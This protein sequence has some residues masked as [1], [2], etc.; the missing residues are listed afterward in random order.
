MGLKFFESLPKLM[1]VQPHS[2]A[3][4][5]ARV[6]S[7]EVLQLANEVLRAVDFISQGRWH[8]EPPFF[9]RTAATASRMFSSVRLTILSTP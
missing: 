6:P 9:L 2:I 7:G 5:C 8:Q 3:E 1:R 4:Q